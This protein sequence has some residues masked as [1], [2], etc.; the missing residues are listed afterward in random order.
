[1]TELRK[2][3][4]LVV[5]VAL[6]LSGCAQAGPAA[7]PVAPTTAPTPSSIPEALTP[8]EVAPIMPDGED[9]T[10]ERVV[11]GDT[12][13][14][15]GG[16]RVRL[17]GIDTPETKDPRKPV[18]CFGTEAAAHMSSLIGPGTPVR[19]VHDVERL[20]RFGRTLAYV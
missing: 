13:V 6:A 14:V 17:I 16:T 3:V 5:G 1:M 10:V 11:D 8:V 15:A 4:L 18:Q 7:T 19:L 20:D 12:I 9:T 2:Y